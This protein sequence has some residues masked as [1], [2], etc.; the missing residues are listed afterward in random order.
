M[1]IVPSKSPPEEEAAEGAEAVE[2]F[3]GCPD[4]LQA[5]ARTAT[6]RRVVDRSALNG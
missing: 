6:H 3:D 1:T 4:L 2:L 5:A